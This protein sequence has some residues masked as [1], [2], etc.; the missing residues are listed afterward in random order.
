MSEKI[1]RRDF[2]KV[3][4]TGIAI[5]TALTGCGPASRFTTREPYTKMP[6]YTYNGQSTYYATT[7][8][9]CPAGCGLVV[10][11]MQGRAIKVEGNPLHPVNLGKTCARGQASLH[12]LYNPDRIQGPGKRNRGESALKAIDWE[13]GVKAVASILSSD[14]RSVVFLSGIANDHVFDFASELF[15]ANGSPKPIR[16]S[17]FAIFESQATLRDATRTLFGTSNPLYFDL[18]N[19]DVAFSFGSSFLETWQNPVANTRAF[20][21]FR[22]GHEKRGYLVHFEPRMSQTA[23]KADEWIPVTAGTEGLVADAISKLVS[24]ARDGVA[25]AAYNLINIEEASKVSGVSLESLERLAKIFANAQAPLALPPVTA[26]GAENG[27]DAVISVLN[28][29]VV[30]NNLGKEGG[31]FISPDVALASQDTSATYLELQSLVADIESGKVKTLLIHGVNPIFELPASLGF[32]AALEKIGTIVS[33][34][35]Y[36]DETSALADYVLPDHTALEGFGYQ[37]VKTSTSVPVISGAQPVVAPFYNTMSTIDLLLAAGII[38]GSKVALPYKDEVEFIQAKVEPLMSATDGYYNGPDLPTFWASFQQFGGWWK[39]ST[40][41]T[42]P[43]APNGIVKTANEFQ[44]SSLKEGELFLLPYLSP[45]LA[46][47][48]AN[49]PWLQEV[50]DPTTTVMWNTWLEIN[51]KTAEEMGLHNDD[52]VKVITESGE[53]EVS[54]LH[55][56]GIRPDVAAIP[57]GQGHKNNGRY[58]SGRGANPADLFGTSVNPAGD[59]IYSGQKVR[60]EKTG[61]KY[62][63]S[64]LEGYT[65]L[66]RDL[67]EH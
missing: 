63:L 24:E 47:A 12:G 57:F 52:V 34:S 25:P 35:S 66:E 44:H 46:E 62:P 40:G 26:S 21:K 10:R 2:L 6:E 14:P 4:G 61:R 11:T 53:I 32:E 67:G 16:S 9:E 30:A 38:A 58:A 60:I 13:E 1:S 18:A 17:A 37:R 59:L 45:I 36:M 27:L 23:M 41:L 55:Y 31:V 42:K 48:G 5:T 22:R 51:P 15:S 8:R 3:A 7:C 43:T 29:N 33:F 19:A 49:K 28:L 39:N 64:R 54:V 50:P 65:K 20:S 56:K